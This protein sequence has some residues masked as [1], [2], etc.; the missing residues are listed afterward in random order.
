MT[1]NVSYSD[2]F[3]AE[4][5]GEN[6]QTSACHWYVVSIGID[7]YTHFRLYQFWSWITINVLCK[8]LLLF[9]FFRVSWKIEIILL[10]SILYQTRLEIFGLSFMITIEIASLWWIFQT[11]YCKNGR[12]TYMVFPIIEFVFANKKKK[13]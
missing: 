3:S 9:L 7:K 2:S 1:Y 10:H 6:H 11:R 8:V 5:C 13:Q 4:K 12:K